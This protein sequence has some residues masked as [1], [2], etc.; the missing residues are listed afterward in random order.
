MY[1]IIMKRL[2][3]IFSYLYRNKKVTFI[4]ILLIAVAGYLII[5]KGNTKIDTVHPKYGKITQSISASGVTE[6]ANFVDLSF[7]TG[8]RLAYVGVKKNDQ[9]QAGQTIAALDQRTLLKN[10]NNALQDFSKQRNIFENTKEDNKNKVLDDELRRILENNQYDLNKALNS[11]E[12]QQLAIDQSVLISPISGVVTRADS[13]VAGINITAQNVYTIA[14]PVHLNFNV[15]VD[16]SD[17]GKVVLNQPV[18]VTLDSYP[19]SPLKLNVSA[20]DF[21]SHKSETGGTVYTVKAQLPENTD[22]KYR[23]GM[24]GDAEIVLAQKQKALL[25]PISSITDET[26][27]YVKNDNKYEKRK[28]SLGLQSETEAE[29]L[30]GVTTDDEIVLVPDDVTKLQPK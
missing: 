24:N 16:E 12:L 21:T 25:I 22:N 1:N 11:V 9:V 28:I 3:K 4:I 20:I 7:I 6:S 8:G 23:I 13:E 17:I 18:S 10:M 19:D 14:D 29:V 2:S 30:S 27:V 15:D 26:S 5:P